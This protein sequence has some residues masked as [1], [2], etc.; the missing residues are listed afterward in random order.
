MAGFFRIQIAIGVVSLLTP[1]LAWAAVLWLGVDPLKASNVALPSLVVC[2]L[3]LLLLPFV[4]RGSAS[5]P[6]VW[7]ATVF[8]WGLLSTVFPIIWDL[9]WAILHEWVAGATA[10][11]KHLWYWW[12]YAVADTRFLRS[13]SLMIILEYWSGVLGV[14]DGIAL[15]C[16]CKGRVQRAFAISSV[17][18]LL[19]FYGCTVFFG[20]E[21]MAGFAN[22]TPDFYSYLKFFGL[23]GLWLCMP[24]L[25]SVCCWKLVRHGGLDVP[26]IFRHELRGLPRKT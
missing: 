7:V 19:Q 18:G 2:W 8:F 11:D 3:M 22:I 20:T 26:E 13:D 10:E 5:K 12:A 21:W 15:Y 16:F 6:A 9:S 23:N 25:A 24:L 17:V 14:A 4:Y 1:G